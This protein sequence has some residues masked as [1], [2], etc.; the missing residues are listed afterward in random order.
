LPNEVKQMET[1]REKSLEL[2]FKAAPL[3]DSL[4][5]CDSWNDLCC[6][7]LPTGLDF[8]LLDTASACGVEAT[9]RWLRIALALREDVPNHT[10]IAA[11]GRAPVRSVIM[12]IESLRKRG[13]RS[14]PG[15]NEQH[16]RWINRT[17]QARR[18]AIKMVTNELERA[19]P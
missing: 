3:S 4:A 5:L 14:K 10:A 8:F 12:D 19:A 17:L 9:G 1:N 7:A 2:V 6:S 13:L 11:A 15:W 16:T 18:A